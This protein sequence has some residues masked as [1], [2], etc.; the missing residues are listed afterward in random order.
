MMTSTI[1]EV[2]SE[3]SQSAQK[4]NVNADIMMMTDSAR[5]FQASPSQFNGYSLR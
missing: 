4:A 5:F 3:C 2:D 1:D